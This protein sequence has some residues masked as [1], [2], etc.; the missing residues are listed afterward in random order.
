MSFISV[1]HV[2]LVRC[3]VVVTNSSSLLYCCKIVVGVYNSKPRSLSIP[4]CNAKIFNDPC[5]CCC[6]IDSFSLMIAQ[7]LLEILYLYATIPPVGMAT[8]FVPEF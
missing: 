6:K 2:C 7:A 5:L 1:D 3:S 8:S 4:I